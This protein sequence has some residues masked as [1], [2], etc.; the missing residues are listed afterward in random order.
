[1]LLSSKQFLDLSLCLLEQPSLRRPERHFCTVGPAVRGGGARAARRYLEGQLRPAGHRQQRRGLGHGLR[2]AP[3]QP[4]GPC[5]RAWGE[6]E[7]NV[8]CVHPLFSNFWKC[9]SRCRGR[10]LLPTFPP[11]TA[12]ALSL[13]LCMRVKI[14]QN[15]TTRYWECVCLFPGYL[16]CSV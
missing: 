11:K 10:C 3:L 4:S 13:S 7:G 12:H 9:P 2:N 8:T 1:M 14:I 6:N 16:T 5:R 15:E